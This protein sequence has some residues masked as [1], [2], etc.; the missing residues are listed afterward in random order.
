MGGFEPLFL[1]VFFLLLGVSLAIFNWFSYVF[2][3]VCQ[4]CYIVLFL[5]LFIFPSLSNTF[6]RFLFFLC[7]FSSVI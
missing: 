1:I 5:Y 4:C 7:L 6:L 2:F 3:F